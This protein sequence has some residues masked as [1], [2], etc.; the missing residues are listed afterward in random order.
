[1]TLGID[2]ARQWIA[3]RTGHLDL[4]GSKAVYDRMKQWLEAKVPKA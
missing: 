4:L 2:P 1:M 3:Y